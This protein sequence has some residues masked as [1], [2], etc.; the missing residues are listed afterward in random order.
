M[1][2][3]KLG[4][5]KMTDVKYQRGVAIDN[6]QGRVSLQTARSGDSGIWADWVYPQKRVD[7]ENEPGEKAIPSGVVLGQGAA[8][9]I[10]TLEFFIDVLKN[11][12]VED[13][14]GY[15]RPEPEDDILF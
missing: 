10:K 12:P 4:L 3:I 5:F 6:Y 8:E 2:E 11:G 9:A 7:G 13:I 1:P 14:D 15:E